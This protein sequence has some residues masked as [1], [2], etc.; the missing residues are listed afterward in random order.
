MHGFVVEAIALQLPG[1]DECLFLNF[2][3]RVGELDPGAFAAV[4]IMRKLFS[5]LARVFFLLAEM[6]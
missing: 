3:R 1:I 2:A 5:Y 6:R 4:S